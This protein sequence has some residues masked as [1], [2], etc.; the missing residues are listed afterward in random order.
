VSKVNATT[1]PSLRPGETQ[2]RLHCRLGKATKHVYRC[3]C[4]I[5]RVKVICISVFSLVVD[6]LQFATWQVSE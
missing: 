1:A 2:R 3:V 6:C 5:G 4:I